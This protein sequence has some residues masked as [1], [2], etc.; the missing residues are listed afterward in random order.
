MVAIKP[1]KWMDDPRHCDSSQTD[2]HTHTHTHKNKL[3]LLV[4]PLLDKAQCTFRANIKPEMR[5]QEVIYNILWWGGEEM[6]RRPIVYRYGD[7]K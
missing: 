7:G 5:E 2:T 6:N 4:T 1:I 3:L